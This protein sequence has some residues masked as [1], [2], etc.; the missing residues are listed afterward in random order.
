MPL[1]PAPT[2]PIS[3]WGIASGAEYSGKLPE[4]LPL[5]RDAG[6]TGLR[7]FPEWQSIQPSPG[8]WNWGESDRLVA[9]AK[10][11]GIRMAGVFLY[12]T[13]WASSDGGTR[14][15]PVKDMQTWRE[16]VKTVVA[17]YRD[18]IDCWE[19]WN[20]V[21][22]PAFNHHG[23][24]QDYADM[25]RTAYAAAKEANPDC[26]IA[27][28]CAAYDLHYFAQTLK[29]GASGCFD[30]VCV[31]PY[32]SIGYVFGSEPS[33]LAMAGNLRAMLAANGQNADMP[34]WISE[35]GLTT[36]P[37][38]E[39]LARQAE[40]LAKAY[41]LSLVQG[42][43]RLYWFEASGPKYG[44]GIHAILNDDLS[45][46]PAYTALAA[47]TKSL[48]PTPRYLGWHA[49]GSNL[50]GFVF[51]SAG[52]YVMAV[53]AVDTD[54]SASFNDSVTVMDLR[55]KVSTL[56]PSAT[57]K[58]TREPVFIRG[59][60]PQIAEEARANATRRFPWAPDYSTE[61]EVW[62]KLGPVNETHGLLQGNNDPRSDGITIPGT[63]ADGSFRSTDLINRRP[64]IYFDVD[65]SFAGWN[66]RDFEIT[67]VARRSQP[68]Q[69]A[70][71]TLV[72]ESETG[73]HEYGKRTTTPGLNV[74]MMFESE[75]FKTPDIRHL[76]AGSDWQ[77][78][79]WQIHDACFIQKWGWTF[80]VNAE[81]SASNISVREV[82]VKKSL[83]KR[84]I[85][86]SCAN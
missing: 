35:I 62:C 23:T 55:G 63:C 2:T 58:L 3:P 19:V 61:K 31:H 21:N 64:F 10:A 39:Q 85:M 79:T 57:L 8:V 44:E 15:F 77:E 47:M 12:F 43:E 29:A 28:T 76:P 41:I 5:L 70:A 16:F 56:P 9:S 75:S 14:G 81:M 65:S 82:R 50:Y 54:A 49:L 22:S 46:L 17:R 4:I 52:A 7:Y 25:V 13:P 26:K 42:F 36:T 1:Q 27:I 71:F 40:A 78:Y 20:E 68:D 32:N 33:Y 24:P 59:V 83:P 66:D 53:W 30:Y 73:Y 11:N 74:E 45:P 34:L 38:L 6:I 18:E 80:Q 67:V 37:A 84:C 60:P 69:P 72:Y 86:D 51:E 48:G